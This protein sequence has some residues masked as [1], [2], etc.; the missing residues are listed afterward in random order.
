M[1][2]ISTLVTRAETIHVTDSLRTESGP[3][4]KRKP[5]DFAKLTF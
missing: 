5:M 2:K 1:T 3:D 4:G